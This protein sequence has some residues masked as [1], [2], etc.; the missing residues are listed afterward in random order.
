[1]GQILVSTR[2]QLKQEVKPNF[3]W[4][5]LSTSSDKWLMIQKQENVHKTII[6]T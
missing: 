6:L 5:I 3:M 1:M 2:T 4:K